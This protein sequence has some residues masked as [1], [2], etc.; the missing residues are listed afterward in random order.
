MVQVSLA[1][2]GIGHHRADDL[3]VCLGHDRGAT[4]VTDELGGALDHAV[5]FT[6]LSAFDLAA[7]R[8]LEPLLAAR[9]G[10]QLRWNARLGMPLRPATRYQSAPYTPTHSVSQ[11]GVGVKDRFG[12]AGSRLRE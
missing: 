8:H 12:P 3:G 5:A 11:G 6:R 7:G 1:L 2:A 4:G 9:L 10:L